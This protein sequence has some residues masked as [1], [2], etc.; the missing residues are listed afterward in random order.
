MI[1]T[2]Y[3]VGVCVE[4]LHRLSKSDSIEERLFQAFNEFDAFTEE[5]VSEEHWA[6]S[7]E[8]I[9]RY[10]AVE[11]AKFLSTSE[12]PEVVSKKTFETLAEDLVNLA[13]EIITSVTEFWAKK[14]DSE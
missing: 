3:A 1:T 11:P 13:T 7:N 2:Q 14:G 8:L 4:T 10:H 6:A 12:A 5:D 9:N